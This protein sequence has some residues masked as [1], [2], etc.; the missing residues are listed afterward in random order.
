MERLVFSCLNPVSSRLGPWF[1]L[2]LGLVGF[3]R[4]EDRQIIVGA[5]LD[6]GDYVEGLIKGVDEILGAD[7]FYR[8][9]PFQD[10]HY[11]FLHPDENR[12]GTAHLAFFHRLLQGEGPGLIYERNIVEA[13][14]QIFYGGKFLDGVVEILD[15]SEK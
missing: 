11:V 1:D 10:L 7:Y 13:Q 15:L 4:I 9:D 3:F 8:T 5:F 2:V 12:P 6:V 14:D